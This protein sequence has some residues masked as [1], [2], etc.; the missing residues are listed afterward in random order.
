MAHARS[1]SSSSFSFSFKKKKSPDP[2]NHLVQYTPPYISNKDTSTYARYYPPS[3]KNTVS[4]STPATGQP[5]LSAAADSD[6]PTKNRRRSQSNPSQHHRT[7]S[8]SSEFFN[9]TAPQPDPRLQR[10][11]IL[12]S[13]RR[14]SN[15][16]QV[17]I[18]TYQHQTFIPDPELE[19]ELNNTNSSNRKTP[20][21]YSISSASR[22]LGDTFS[23][24]NSRIRSSSQD[25]FS[26]ETTTQPNRSFRLSM[27]RQRSS[28]D[29]S[30]GSGSVPDP[31]IDLAKNIP[32]EMMPILTLL[33]AQK[34]RTYYEG[35]FMIL[36]DL[37][38]GKY[39]Q[40]IF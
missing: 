39:N 17:S 20:S 1:L 22:H 18:N 29:V 2:P 3:R 27:S 36:N 6:S 34:Q 25:T 26:S 12:G 23:R 21:I 9:S 37:N 13:I 31:A 5:A 16:S 4:T 10:R 24:R 32:H 30:V 8:V 40:S 35:Y 28:S 38:S 19:R 7:L 15:A 11:S 14:D 33:H